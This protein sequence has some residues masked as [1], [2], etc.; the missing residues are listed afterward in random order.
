[1]K[2]L[3]LLFYLVIT[4]A[5]KNSESISSTLDKI[6]ND[7][8][9][10][11]S[12]SP[13]GS[14]LAMEV[15]SLIENRSKRL[16]ALLDKLRDSCLKNDSDMIMVQFKITSKGDLEDINIIKSQLEDSTLSIKTRGCI[17]DILLSKDL[18]LGVMK[19]VP[20]ARNGFNAQPILYTL[21][22]KK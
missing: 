15:D 11:A 22:I 2:Y 3:L 12:P 14:K 5:Y 18:N 4:V 21:P 9:T 13:Y 16:D 17:M 6:D 20:N 1:M 10:I 8:T 7:A 19:V